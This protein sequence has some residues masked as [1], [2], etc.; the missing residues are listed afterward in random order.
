MFLV[1][2]SAHISPRSLLSLAIHELAQDLVLA[3]VALG[4]SI[5][6]PVPISDD[7]TGYAAHVIPRCRAERREGHRACSEWRRCPALRRAPVLSTD[8]ATCHGWSGPR[9]CTWNRCRDCW[10]P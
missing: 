7:D 4:R 1:A 8:D 6:T 10:G 9:S 5:A 2:T 3:D